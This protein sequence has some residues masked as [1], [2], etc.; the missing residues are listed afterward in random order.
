MKFTALTLLATLSFSA[1]AQGVYLS[2]YVF[3]EFVKGTVLKKS[4]SRE[5]ALLNYNSLTQEMIFENNG[6]KLALAQLNTIDTV[7]IRHSKFVPVDSTFF[8]VINTNSYPLYVRHKT[9]L[10]IPGTPI[11]YGTSTQSASATSLSSYSKAALGRTIYDLKLPDNYKLK[12][13]TEF[14][15]K[16]NNRFIRIN[17]AGSLSKIFPGKEKNIRD[18]ANK[19][20]PDFTRKEDLVTLLNYLTN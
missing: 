7:Y 4:G 14:F 8:E 19:N 6:Q 3:P 13:Q 15:V 12:P 2:H 16:R 18:F 10:E 1:S 17:G 11:G 9:R 5:Q 20:R